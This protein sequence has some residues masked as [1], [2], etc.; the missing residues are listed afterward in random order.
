M[1]HSRLFSIFAI[2]AIVVSLFAAAMPAFAA[3]VSVYT[4]VANKVQGDTFDLPIMINTTTGIRAYQFN[5]TFD[6]TRLTVNTVKDGGWLKTAGAGNCLVPVAPVV[7]NVAGTIK[8]MS[9]SLLGDPTNTVS[10]TGPLAIINVTVKSA[11]P[12]GKAALTFAPNLAGQSLGVKILDINSAVI[13]LSSVAPKWV[14]VGPGPDLRMALAFSP[15]GTGGAYNLKVTV[16]NNGG[17]ASDADVLQ[18]NATNVTAGGPYTFTV[19]ALGVGASQDFSVPGLT[20]TTGA[21]NSV[22]TALLQVLGTS[23]S[24]TYSPVFDTGNVPVDASFGA[25]LKLTVPPAQN[26]GN[27]KLGA[28][29]ITSTL[30]VKCNT[31][32]EVDVMDNGTTAW[33]MTEYDGAAYKS[34]KLIDTLHVGSSQ[35]PDITA[36]SASFFATSGVAG[37]AGDAGENFTTTFSQVLHYADPLLPSGETYHMELTF[38]AFQTM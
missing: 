28:N 8:G 5:L 27:L 9:C 18:V 6:P 14:Q 37:Q 34:I 1:K 19:P 23:K 12:N 29:V 25:F 2:V 7:D 10:G 20:L 24:A 38:N 21:P 33:K 11:A 31:K 26:F 4:D 36:G 13:A 17:S 3:G 22:V 16:T 30:N 35:V 32:Y 15:I